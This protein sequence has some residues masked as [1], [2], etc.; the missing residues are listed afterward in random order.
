[1][2]LE[3]STYNGL[4][5]PV[6]WRLPNMLAAGRKIPDTG[7]LRGQKPAGRFRNG[8]AQF[9]RGFQPLR[10]DDFGVCEGFLTSG[11]V[12]GAASQLGDYGD[13]RLV[14][15]APVENDLVLCHSDSGTSLYRMTTLRTC[16][17]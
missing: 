13:E 12:G 8:A 16:L 17:T 3:G 6:S 5:R 7:I 9:P 4:F 10:D 15:A 2:I 11:A 14:L 1:M